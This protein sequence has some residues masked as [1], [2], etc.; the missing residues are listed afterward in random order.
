ML[1][2]NSLYIDLTSDE[3]FVNDKEPDIKDVIENV[4]PL[5]SDFSSAEEKILFLEGLKNVDM[6]MD[7]CDGLIEKVKKGEL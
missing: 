3:K 1:P 2:L 4:K 6:F 7:Y 5:L